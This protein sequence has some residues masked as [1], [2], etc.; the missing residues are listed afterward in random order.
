MNQ[1]DTEYHSNWINVTLNH[2]NVDT[3][4]VDDSSF[5]NKTGKIIIPFNNGAAIDNVYLKISMTA[6]CNAEIT[7]I[8]CI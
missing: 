8:T 4:Y 6:E 3:R 5:T 2:Q 1:N 7:Q